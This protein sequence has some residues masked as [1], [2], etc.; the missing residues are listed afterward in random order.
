MR[1]PK[2][3]RPEDLPI[4]LIAGVEFVRLRF[5]L[6]QLEQTAVQ[7]ILVPTIDMPLGSEVAYRVTELA[8]VIGADIIVL[9]VVHAFD[10]NSYRR[11]DLAIELFEEAAQNYEFGLEGYIMNGDPGELISRMAEKWNVDLILLGNDEEVDWNGWGID[12]K[13]QTKRVE[14]LDDFYQAKITT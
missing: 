5:F 2:V 11:G 8:N 1:P 3:N 12:S 7:K 9:F 14:M 4:T 10:G 6:L 13:L